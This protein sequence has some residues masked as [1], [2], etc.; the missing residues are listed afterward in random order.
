MK[1]LIFLSTDGFSYEREAL[2]E[3]FERGKFTSPMTNLEISPEILENSM[4][5]ERIGNFL[6]DMDFDAFTFEQNEEI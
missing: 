5:R 6:R 3:W 4:L 2:E 1:N